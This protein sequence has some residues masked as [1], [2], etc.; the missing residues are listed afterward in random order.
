MFVR[1]IILT[2]I[3]LTYTR[4]K[5]PRATKKVMQAGPVCV[6]FGLARCQGIRLLNQE[7]K[8]E[9]TISTW[10]VCARPGGRSRI[11]LGKSTQVGCGREPSTT[12]KSLA[13]CGRESST[14]ALATNPVAS[15]VKRDD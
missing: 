1:F 15:L 3:H 11:N 10:F 4:V 8:H 5:T 6:I 7:K 9:T 13:G 14:A 2:N 12:A